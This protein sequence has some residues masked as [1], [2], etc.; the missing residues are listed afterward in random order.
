[1]PAWRT[2]RSTSATAVRSTG[3]A[4]RQPSSSAR[5]RSPSSS[6]SAP[7]RD[8]G[9]RATTR[10]SSSSTSVPPAAT[11]ST[12]PKAGSRTTPIEI[13]TPA[14]TI[15]CTVTSAP[16]RRA[17]AVYSACSCHGV[18]DP[19]HDTTDVAL[20][21]G[22]KRSSA[23]RDSRRHCAAAN[24]SS[25]DPRD[26]ASAP[27]ERRSRRAGR[28]P[29]SGVQCGQ[30]VQPAS[31]PIRIHV[32]PCRRRA[33]VAT[34]PGG[35]A[36]PARCACPPS[37][38]IPLSRSRSA[39]ALVDG[40][41]HRGQHRQRG[42]GVRCDVEYRVRIRGVAVELGDQVDRQRGDGDRGGRRR[43]PADR[44]GTAP[45]VSAPVPQTSSGLVAISP[46]SSSASMAFTVAS[47]SDGERPRQGR[48]PR[49]RSAHAR[50]PS[51]ARSRCRC[52]ARLARRPAQN[53][54]MVSVNSAR[55]RDPNRADGVAERVPA[56]VLTGQRARVRGDH[57]TPG[58][59][60]ADGQ[61]Y[62][63]HVTLGGPQQRPAQPGCRTRESPSAE[64]PGRCPDRRARSRRNRLCR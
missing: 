41:R 64:P 12:G 46:S 63:R 48:A 35:R 40:R 56:R 43:S 21:L 32:G 13:S 5:M 58:R 54:S 57:G 29:A 25:R 51:R 52:A 27:P 28:T 8:N 34:R 23:R 62:H 45:R 1:M 50:R 39:V 26:T 22:A 3:A 7:A 15:G 19:E 30:S 49:R 53:S 2:R 36:P 38:G 16:S 11:T 10:S 24:A 17:I 18:G 20:V 60:A 42:V 44:P 9:G 6:R 37:T 59:R 47:D 61:D 31:S 33:D 4:P 14:S 55:S